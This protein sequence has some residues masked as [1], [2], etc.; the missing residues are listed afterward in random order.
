MKPKNSITDITDK[1]RKNYPVDKS[2]EILFNLLFYSFN[3]DEAGSL[4][5]IERSNRIYLYRNIDKLLKSFYLNDHASLKYFFQDDY[6]S[7]E[8]IVIP[9]LWEM[10][11]LANGS[12]LYGE[13]PGEE[14]IE[15]HRFYEELTSLLYFLYEQYKRK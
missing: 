8:D 2:S 10:L 9:M 15:L 14:R 11:V 7:P 3:C 4:D 6:G 1:F 12:D 13:S 5:T